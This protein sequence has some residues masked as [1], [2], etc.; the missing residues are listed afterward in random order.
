M[1]HGKAIYIYLPEGTTNGLIT[2]ELSNWNGYGIKIS[3]TEVPDCNRPQLKRPGVYFLIC[4][5]DGQ[6]DGVYVGESEN[7]K[8]RLL[9][10]LRDYQSEKE[11]FYWY[12]AVTFTSDSL[13]K[14]LIRYLENKLAI[15]V[16]KAD[17]TIC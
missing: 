13:N 6:N 12:T 5:G 2:A 14:T 9:Q 7:V 4:K 3:R 8:E 16:K 17:V 10:H 15:R 1:A 11:K